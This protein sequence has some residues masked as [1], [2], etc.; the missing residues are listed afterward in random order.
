MPSFTIASAVSRAGND[1]RGSEDREFR[2]LEIEG[3]SEGRRRHRACLIFSPA[4]E[5]A[6]TVP[7]GYV[8]E[9]ADG[10]V[11]LVGWLPAE[12]FTLYRDAVS[13]GEASKVLYE[14]RDE[15]T[16]YLRRIALTR[17]HGPAV[18]AGG[19]RPGRGETRGRTL[20][21]AFAMPL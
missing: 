9:D 19:C 2:T 8:A 3:P 16:G 13:S 14:T 5:A 18:A 15:T 21:T 20:R 11:S 10:G 17:E 4:V 12:D 7:V 6:R 1:R